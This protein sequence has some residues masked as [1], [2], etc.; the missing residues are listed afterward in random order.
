[1]ATPLYNTSNITFQGENAGFEI[2]GPS[3]IIEVAV[4]IIYDCFQPSML[5][6]IVDFAHFHEDCCIDLVQ[7]WTT[8]SRFDL[9]KLFG[10]FP[11]L[12]LIIGC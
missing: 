8:S 6:N 7:P 9:E 11:T 1:M 4:E 3:Y 2:F 12:A 5:T 10:S